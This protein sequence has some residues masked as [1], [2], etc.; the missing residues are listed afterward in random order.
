MTAS[1]KLSCQLP[2][3][4][5]GPDGIQTSSVLDLLAQA[6]EADIEPDCGVGP[7]FRRMS[8][9]IPSELL[10]HAK[11]QRFVRMY[12]EPVGCLIGRLI[13]ANWRAQTS[14][15]TLASAQ[16]QNIKPGSPSASGVLTGL[17]FEQIEAVGQIYPQL[18]KRRIVLAE[19][20][21]GTGKGRVLAYSA[22]YALNLRDSGQ[23]D[24]QQ[25]INDVVLMPAFL[26]DHA[27]RVLELQLSRGYPDGWVRYAPVILAAP[28]IETV[29]H[30][31]REWMASKPTVDAEGQRKLAIVFG[32]QQFVCTSRLQAAL[33]Q[34]PNANIQAWLDAGMPPGQ[35]STSQHLR[36]CGAGLF[37]MM[38]DLETLAAPSNWPTESIDLDDD[39]SES[40][41]QP[42]QMQRL[43]ALSCDLIFTTHAMVA[44]NNVLLSKEHGVPPLPPCCALM[45]DEAD[46]FESAQSAQAGHSFSLP[47]L[48][49]RLRGVQ[50]PR[51]SK[52]LITSIIRKT[53]SLASALVDMPDR[54]TLPILTQDTGLTQIWQDAQPQLEELR[55]SLQI[56]VESKLASAV[57]VG[58]EQARAI[59]YA[60]RAALAL[61]L[62]IDNYRGFV[63]HTPKRGALSLNIGPTSVGTHLLA[64]WMTSP[65][66]VLTSGTLLNVTAAGIDTAS[67]VMDW[68][69]PASRWVVIQPVHPPWLWSTATVYTPA[70]CARLKLLPPPSID[71]P[72]TKAKISASQAAMAEW[73]GTV[74][75]TVAQI[76]ADSVGGS[77]ILM[78]GY[79]RANIVSSVLTLQ[80][81]DL[82]DRIICS[83]RDRSVTSLLADFKN[84]S[85]RGERPI[86]FATGAAGVG[87]DILDKDISDINAANDTLLT[88][89]VIPCLPYG[90]EH[91]QSHIFRV[92]RAGF[93]VE[94]AAALRTFRQWLGRLVRRPGLRN[95]R[96]WVLD[97][98]LHHPGAA[99]YVSPFR[100]VL[101]RYLNRSEFK[102]HN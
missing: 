57:D 88:D 65:T 46:R 39:D 52:K 3:L 43:N 56:L 72:P 21:T 29:S 94:N 53:G 35:T 26:R 31:V 4:C 71:G 23:L 49:Q 47:M 51:G 12:R 93:V 73:A 99:R 38:A 64:G 80:R 34:K 67:T 40:D 91:S 96:I 97:G 14:K 37:G 6:L 11:L 5:F 68:N 10:T 74:A 32:R 79:D 62:T 86:W 15:T 13:F 25:S 83:S 89:L 44:L 92:K 30:L 17:R 61:K 100:T 66:I 41:Q 98:R 45:L 101:L 16:A 50:W 81:P 78:T 8:I 48:Q 95:R 60:T 102:I 2:T 18:P 75:K 70:E 76:T 82:M 55:T 20:G 77:L 63:G 7:T 19:L 84:R 59:R 27:R 54:T 33:L 1:V 28:T 90:T 22:A 58:V 42:Y 87:M 24:G 85:K 36:D 69:I 9:A